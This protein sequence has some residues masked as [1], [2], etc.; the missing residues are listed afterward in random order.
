MV[1]EPECVPVYNFY[2]EPAVM[3]GCYRPYFTT[4]KNK[5]DLEFN[6]LQTQK[7][8]EGSAFILQAIAR[9]I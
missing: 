4:L 1:P 9:S 3:S 8:V 2:D 5:K 6:A 7:F